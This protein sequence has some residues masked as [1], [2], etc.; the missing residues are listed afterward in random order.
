MQKGNGQCW[1][2]DTLNKIATFTSTFC[3]VSFGK[4]I[5][6]YI[7]LVYFNLDVVVDFCYHVT[8]ME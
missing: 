5:K 1:P 4:N 8:I 2:N 3:M 6:F 7:I